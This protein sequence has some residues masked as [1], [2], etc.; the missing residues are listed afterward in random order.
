MAFARPQTRGFAISIAAMTPVNHFESGAV[1]S[2]RGLI[3]RS[4]P[5]SA[6]FE[7]SVVPVID[8]APRR[9]FGESLR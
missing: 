8:F 7:H 3:A 9:S 6:R 5:R 4:R 1:P 2:M